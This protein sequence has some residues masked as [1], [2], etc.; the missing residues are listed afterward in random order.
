MKIPDNWLG[1]ATCTSYCRRF[2]PKIGI[3]KKHCVGKFSSSQKFSKSSGDFHNFCFGKSQTSRFH[4]C[5]KSSVTL[6]SPSPR[7]QRGT[8][9]QEMGV[10]VQV[11]GGVGVGQHEQVNPPHWPS[12]STLFTRKI[13]IW[14]KRK[15]PRN[16]S[17]A[18]CSVASNIREAQNAGCGSE[19]TVRIGRA[20]FF[21]R[22]AKKEGQNLSAN[23]ENAGIKK[24]QKLNSRARQRTAP[25]TNPAS[26]PQTA[27]DTTAHALINAR[28]SD[29]ALNFLRRSTG[30][31]FPP[32]R[33]RAEWV[34]PR[35]LSKNRTY[36]LIV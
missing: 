10:F 31:C 13:T 23:E 14:L 27:A 28:S 3:L 8:T 24:S 9:R 19:Q 22:P 29:G 5:G 16:G 20:E 4:Y 25:L 26:F 34:T 1:S 30:K 15:F 12:H 18:Y 33:D 36:L 11:A 2:W 21:R 35:R 7:R 6:R 32:T 17:W